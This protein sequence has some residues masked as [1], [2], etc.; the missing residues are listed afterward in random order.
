M[1]NKELIY[2]LAQKLNLII[3]VTKNG[4]TT[5]YKFIDGKLHKFK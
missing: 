4:I 1:E 5:T 2:Q 3:E